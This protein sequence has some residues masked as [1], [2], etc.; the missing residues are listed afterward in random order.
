MAEETPN[1]DAPAKKKLPIKMVAVMAVMLLIE[2]AAIVGIFMFAGGPDE[3]KAD[4]VATSLET[5]GELPAEVLVIAEKFQNTR[6][7]RAYVYDT[8]I[9][10]VVKTKNKG[11]AEMAMESMTAQLN[12]DIAQIF[13]KAEPTHLLEPELS[14]LTRQIQ[15]KLDE[16]FGVDEDA[17]PVIQ[18]V[19]I[20]KCEQYRADL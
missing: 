17:Q 16:R 20:P 2:G 4:S 7:G 15:S 9:W 5:Q 1:A 14:T 10:I 8:E 13:R 19:L 18:Q 12:T 11:K 3:V 6:T